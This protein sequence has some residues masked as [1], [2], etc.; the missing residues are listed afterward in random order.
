MSNQD[1]FRFCPHC[2]KQGI[3]LHPDHAL[4]CDE[5]G[6]VLFINVATAVGAI[7]A[8]ER[9]RILLLRR[10]H[11]PAK[12]KLGAPGGFVSPGEGAEQALIREV[13]EETNLEVTDLRYLCSA[14]NQYPY[15]GILYT[16][17]DFYFVCTVRTLECLQALDEVDSCV[18]LEPEGIREEELAFPTLRT[19]LREYAGTR[20]SR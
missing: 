16:T 18:L 6:F 2:G 14:P 15:R 17:V 13:K 5:C 4:R 12:G 9:G 8:D 19:A 11:E 20:V 1:R 7:I 3:A 10:S